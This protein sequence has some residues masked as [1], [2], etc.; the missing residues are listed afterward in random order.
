MAGIGGLLVLVTAV[1]ATLGVYQKTFVSSTDVTVLS[2]RA[3]LLLDRGAKVRVN[4]VPV[5]EVRSVAVGRDQGARIELALDPESAEKI[6]AGT[7]A[8]ITPTTVFGA[9][10]VDLLVPEGSGLPAQRI[11]AGDTIHV[12]EVSVEANDVFGAIQ[13][14]LTTIDP[15]QINSTLTAMATALEGRGDE[16]GE[17]LV[18]VNDYVAALNG[19]TDALVA[20]I[21]QGARVAD[22]YADVSPH[23]LDIGKQGAVTAATLNEKSATLQALLVDFTAA[24]DRTRGFLGAIES[25]LISALDV[26]RPVLA[27]FEK[28]SPEFTCVL[29]ALV[30]HRDA[31]NEVLGGHEPG[32]QG[33][34]SLLPASPGYEYPRDLPKLI[35]DAQPDCLSLPAMEI[36]KPPVRRFDDGSPGPDDSVGLDLSKPPAQVYL[37]LVEEWFGQ[38][39]LD[40]LLDKITGRREAP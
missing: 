3:G 12:A 18:R 38:T 31:V 24:A 9:K 34:V 20:D 37:G 25:P 40:M 13:D 22:L 11:E 14:L 39:G 19:S 1:G 32:I 4:G 30:K 29:Q 8:D 26:M 27:S 5:G 23:L 7:R 10:Y 36:P 33:R 15:H 35:P 28:F 17:Y 21:R 16:L 2:G 6:P